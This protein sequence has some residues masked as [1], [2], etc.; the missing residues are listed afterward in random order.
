MALSPSLDRVFAPFEGT[1]DPYPVAIFRIAF[2]GGLA[3]HFFPTLLWVN[4]AYRPGA[5]RTQEWSET[6]YAEFPRI[7]HGAVEALALVT[8]VACLCALVGFRPRVAAAVSGAGLYAFASFNG[9]HVQTLALIDAW[10]ILLLWALCGGGSAVLSV[11]STLLRRGSPAVEPRLL[12]GLVVYQVLLGV[13]FA[14][15]EKVIA[16]WPGTN[17]MG[18]LLSYPKGFVVRDWVADSAWLRGPAA[19]HGMTWFTLVAE[20][21]TP[22]GLLF[23]RTRLVALVLYEAFFLGIIAM[24]EVPPLFYFTFAFGALLALSDEEVSGARRVWRRI[25]RAEGGAT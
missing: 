10:A 15:V 5:L 3:L 16:G 23:R 18:I 17:E 24:L 6:L 22:I 7:P 4:E 1:R 12:S 8:I 20:L 9:L 25:T 19:T 13:F 11:D 2:F 14:G 21:G